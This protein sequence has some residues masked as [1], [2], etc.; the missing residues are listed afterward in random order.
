[1]LDNGYELILD[2]NDKFTG[3]GHNAGIVEDDA[4][5]TWMYYHAYQLSNLDLHRQSMLDKV[6][7]D[8]DGWPYIESGTPSDSAIAPIVKSRK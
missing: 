1:M 7:W 2:K 5:Q 8:E 3:P 6:L 4:G